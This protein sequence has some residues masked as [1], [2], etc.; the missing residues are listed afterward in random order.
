MN[1]VDDIQESKALYAPPLV[2]RVWS[3]NGR[4]MLSWGLNSSRDSSEAKGL[5]SSLFLLEWVVQGFLLL[6][7]HMGLEATTV[8]VAHLL[9]FKEMSFTEL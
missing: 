1:F 9:P 7:A 8:S 5:C 6:G 4:E 3:R 2:L